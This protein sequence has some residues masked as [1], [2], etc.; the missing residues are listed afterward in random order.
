M[1]IIVQLKLRAKKNLISSSCF[2]WRN[3]YLFVFLGF[4][5]CMCSFV[6]ANADLVGTWLKE[7]DEFQTFPFFPSILAQ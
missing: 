3:I 2:K 1:K 6:F 4:I 7:R 5:T